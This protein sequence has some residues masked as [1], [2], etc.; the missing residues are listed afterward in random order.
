[1]TSSES[2]LAEFPAEDVAEF[3]EYLDGLRASGATNMFG[4]TPYVMDEFDMDRRTAE[5][6]LTGW[7]TTFSNEP[8]EERARAALAK[9]TETEKQP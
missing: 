2:P 8:A 4:A 5:A 1:M 9:A 6:V 3:F 7:M